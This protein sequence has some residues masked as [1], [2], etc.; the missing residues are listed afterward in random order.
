VGHYCNSTIEQLPLQN[1]SD[2]TVPDDSTNPSDPGGSMGS[3]DPSSGQ[4]DNT[5]PSSGTSNG[6]SGGS[7]GGSSGMTGDP[8]VS[9]STSS[10]NAGISTYIPQ[11]MKSDNSGKLE[12]PII[13]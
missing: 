11:V 13:G 2:P 6:S 9:D 7:M 3:S 12:A 4:N 8:V 1:P 10:G 5:S